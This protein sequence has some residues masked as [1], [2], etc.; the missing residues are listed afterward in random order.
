MD[1]PTPECHKGWNGVGWGGG[2]VGTPPLPQVA[3]SSTHIRGP[4]LG[5]SPPTVL[6]TQQ[7]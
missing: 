6:V 7:P 2:G 1:I 4:I 3:P 5:Q